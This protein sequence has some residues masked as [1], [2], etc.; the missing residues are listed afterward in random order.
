MA[1]VRI[2][3]EM[4]ITA[5]HSFM[6]AIPS[7]GAFIR[8]TNPRRRKASVKWGRTQTAHVAARARR[9][10]LRAVRDHGLGVRGHTPPVH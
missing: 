9:V 1:R 8:R 5:I 6:P 3:T 10:V 4:M 2:P 7:P